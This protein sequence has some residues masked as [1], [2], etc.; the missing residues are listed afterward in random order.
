[1]AIRPVET[2][3]AKLQESATTDGSA[4]R[5]HR[6]LGV[7]WPSWG[8]TVTEAGFEPNSLD[9]AFDKDFLLKS[10]ASAVSDLRKFPTDP[11]L[12]LY[13][14]TKDGFPPAKAFQRH[15]KTKAQRV[16]ALMDYCERTDDMSDVLEVCRPLLVSAKETSIRTEKVGK[17][18][19][20][21]FVYLMRS[22]KYYKIGK[23][24]HVG[25][26]EYQI[27]LKLPEP[28]KTVHSIATD[29]P[30]GIEVYWH[31]RFE[32]K[33]AEGEWFSLN[34]DDVKAFKIRK[35]M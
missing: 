34:Q 10:L 13:G 33:R 32:G 26:R 1:M 27:G 4:I 2:S 12:A 16:G 28:V 6:W 5:H 18:I 14:Q 30:D 23:S 15:F 21:G 11:E 8:A 29:D 19:I 25:R 31:N 9:A 17:P 7:Y 22:G 20:K 35:F 3:F 24:N